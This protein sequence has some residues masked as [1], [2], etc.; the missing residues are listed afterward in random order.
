MCSAAVQA[1]Q[2]AIPHVQWDV[3]RVDQNY[4][5][6]LD[7]IERERPFVTPP[8]NPGELHN[9]Y[10]DRIEKARAEHFDIPSRMTGE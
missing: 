5:D 10:M 3:W 2:D 1:L 7:D 8:P 4:R 6:Y 9:D